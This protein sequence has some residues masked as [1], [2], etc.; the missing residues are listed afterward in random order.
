MVR[1]LSYARMTSPVTSYLSGSGNGG[2]S[3]GVIEIID[4]RVGIA[5]GGLF[6]R[7]TRKTETVSDLLDVIVWDL[8]A[9][10]PHSA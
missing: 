5:R 1:I 2:F 8:V 7:L 10:K 9:A 6:G 3:R 4:T